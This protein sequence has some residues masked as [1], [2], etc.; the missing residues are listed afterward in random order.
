MASSG[1]RLWDKEAIS[2]AVARDGCGPAEGQES[3]LHLASNN[4]SQ[5][6]GTRGHPGRV[7]GRAVHPDKDHGP[8]QEQHLQRPSF[9]YASP[10]LHIPA[11]WYPWELKQTPRRARDTS[12]EEWMMLMGLAGPKFLEKTTC[13]ERLIPEPPGGLMRRKLITS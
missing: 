1:V 5:Q 2:Q 12:T 10:G 11:A 8:H 6:A 4:R 7:G 3:H 9:V 13:Q